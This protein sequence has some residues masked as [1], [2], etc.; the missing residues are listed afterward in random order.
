MSMEFRP[1]FTEKFAI[2][3]D[4]ASLKPADLWLLDRLLKNRAIIFLHG[5]GALG[6]LT[7]GSD[8]DFT[9]IIPQD[10]D[11]QKVLR[12]LTEL[13]GFD[14]SSE[15]LAATDYLSISTRAD[16]REKRKISY[17]VQRPSF[18]FNGRPYGV[19]LRLEPK[20]NGPSRYERIFFDQS[21]QVYVVVLDCPQQKINLPDGKSVDLNYTPQTGPFHVYNQNHFAVNVPGCSYGSMLFRSNRM[22]EVDSTTG[23]P[24]LLECDTRDIF[25]PNESVYSDGLEL[26]KA[27]TDTP[28]TPGQEIA[29]ETFVNR[30]IK[31]TLIELAE[32]TDGSVLDAVR[33]MTCGLTAMS[34][35]RKRSDGTLRTSPENIATISERMLSIAHSF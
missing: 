35:V 32:F 1:S 25:T 33:M 19:E 29:L 22:Y 14:L 7:N 31:K 16:N 2:M 34:E 3:L 10:S 21:G 30:K 12:Y 11:Y 27:L 26:G 5:T 9:A 23:K 6:T 18:R 17:H 8:I 15:I 24:N 4:K 20:L 28:V 13:K